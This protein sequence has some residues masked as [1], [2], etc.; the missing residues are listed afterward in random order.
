LTSITD[1][2]VSTKEKGATMP[3]RKAI[4]EEVTNEE[5]AEVMKWADRFGLKQTYNSS[6]GGMQINGVVYRRPAFSLV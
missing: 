4:I 6:Q 2:L 5:Y 1:R 3:K